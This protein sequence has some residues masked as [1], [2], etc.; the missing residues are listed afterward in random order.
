MSDSIPGYV[1][2]ADPLQA[3]ERVVDAVGRLMANT[4][5]DQ[6]AATTPC[7]GWTVRDLLDH[8][9]EV[10]AEYGALAAHG[11]LPDHAPTHDDPVAAFPAVAAEARAAFAAPSYLDAVADTPIGPQP[12]RVV[13][14]HVVNELIMHGWDLA[15]ATGQ[16]TDLEPDL[17]EVALASWRAFFHAY[18][19]DRVSANFYSAQVAPGEA[20]AADRL[21]AYLGRAV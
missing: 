18:D 5:T 2:L 6:V 12:G 9:V 13:I 21:A 1:T 16:D 15:R 4:R 10:V 11:A 19:R 14:Q 17:A 7:D 3:Y 20:S 8:L